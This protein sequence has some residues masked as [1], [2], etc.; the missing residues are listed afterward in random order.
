MHCHSVHVRVCLICLCPVTLLVIVPVVSKVQLSPFLYIHSAVSP[1]G[2]FSRHVDVLSHFL[3]QI[4]QILLPFVLSEQK[5]KSFIQN[6]WLS[7]NN[8]THI[9]LFCFSTSIHV[10]LLVAEF[11]SSCVCCKSALL[12]CRMCMTPLNSCRLSR[13]SLCTS[14]I[15]TCFFST[16]V[17]CSVFTPVSSIPLEP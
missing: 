1:A 14:F 5:E 10:V 13:S 4:S 3:L 8:H 2:T 7:D 11:T 17:D 12:C 15:S 6:L 9:Q 16:S